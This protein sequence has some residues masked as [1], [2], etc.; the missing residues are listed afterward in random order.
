MKKINLLLV[1]ILMSFCGIQ[2]DRDPD[3][4]TQRTKYDTDD[5]AIWVNKKDPSKSI[6]FG[7]DKNKDG[8]VYAFNLEG[9]IIREKTIRGLKKPNN[10][11]IRYDF[12]INNSRSVD[13]LVVTE[14][15]THQVRLYSVPHMK[16][17]DNGGFRVFEDQVETKRKTP[18]GVSFYQSPRDNELYIIVSRKAGPKENYLYQYLV[19]RDKSGLKLKLVRKFGNFSGKGEIEA[20]AVDD[21]LGFVYYSDENYGVRKY[22]A[23][24]SMGNEELPSLTGGKFLKDIEGIAIVP[25]YK[26]KGYVIVS[27]QH[28]GTFNIYSRISNEFITETNLGTSGTDGCEVTTISLNDTFKNGLFVAMNNSRNFFYYDL[29]KLG[30]STIETKR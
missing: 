7:T 28:A 19:V 2:N 26:G 16:A 29:E 15:E 3:V 18:M 30:L 4:I 13:V 1:I 5:P 22:Y 14:R 10:I 12:K 17:L 20:I 25:D 27:N 24:P 23:E 21:E 6:V 11:D 9:K 8:A